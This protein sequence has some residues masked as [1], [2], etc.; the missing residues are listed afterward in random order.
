[1][2]YLKNEKCFNNINGIENI[3]LFEREEV[4]N[5]IIYSTCKE[6]TDNYYYAVL[7]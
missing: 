4:N 6:V 1:M 2:V 7:N 5:K 3:I